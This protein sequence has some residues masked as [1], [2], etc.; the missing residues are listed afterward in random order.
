MPLYTALGYFLLIFYGKYEGAANT[1]LIRP[2]LGKIGA[3]QGLPNNHFANYGVGA[4]IVVGGDGLE[5]PT[6]SV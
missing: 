5:P 3:R 4:G 1:Q 6:P 2:K